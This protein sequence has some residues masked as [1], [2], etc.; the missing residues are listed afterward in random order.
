MPTTYF[1]SGDV[2]KAKVLVIGHDPRLKE[3]DTLAGYAFFGDYFFKKIP[4]RGNELAKYRLAAAVYGYIA[5]LTSYK[6]SANQI[7]LTNLCNESLPHSPKGKIVYIPEDTARK[8]INEIQS[9]LDKSDVKVI[10]AMSAQ[11]NYWLQKLGFYLEVP[12]YLSAAEPKTKGVFHKPPYYEQSKGK[13]F[14]HICGKQYLTKDNRQIYPILHVKN[15][16][17]KGPFVKPYKKSY[18]QCV[19]S[20]K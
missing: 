9:I 3:S 5:Y 1:C 15:W 17:L 10:F 19:N 2:N 13:P 18:E 14:S 11:V 16:P 4:T 8:G 6:Y 12:E 20:L 7:I